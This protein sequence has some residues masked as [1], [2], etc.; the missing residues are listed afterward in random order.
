MTN[1]IFRD[2]FSDRTFGVLAGEYHATAMDMPLDSLASGN[3]QRACASVIKNHKGA[4]KILDSPLKDLLPAFTYALDLDDQESNLNK[5]MPEIQVPVN[6]SDLATA[7]PRWPSVHPL[8]TKDDE[9]AYVRHIMV[10]SGVTE[11]SISPVQSDSRQMISDI[12]FDQTEEQLE[13]QE[14]ARDQNA[15]LTGEQRTVYQKQALD[16]RV[17]FDS[18]NEVLSGKFHPFLNPTTL[19]SQCLQT[20]PTGLRL[21]QEVWEVLQE[22]HFS[23]PDDDSLYSILQKDFT[24]KSEKWVDFSTEIWELGLDLDD[25][26][27]VEVMEAAVHDLIDFSTDKPLPSPSTNRDVLIS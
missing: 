6:I 18:I 16:R 3:S 9:K 25:M 23:Q 8:R 4:G 5:Q 20:E 24:H 19:G 27:F 12:Y 21:V 10:L 26:I 17:L 22:K 7:I 15:Y 11:E 1:H 14:S 13:L 2:G